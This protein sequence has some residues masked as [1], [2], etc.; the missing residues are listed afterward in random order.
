[1]ANFGDFPK[2]SLSSNAE[3]MSPSGE[4]EQ[5]YWRKRQPNPGQYRLSCAARVQGSLVIHVPEESQARKQIIRK[6]ANS[7]HV[8]I[9]PA[10]RQYFVK[11]KIVELG[12][13][14]GDWERLQAALPE[15]RI[16]YFALRELQSTLRQGHWEVTITVWN[17]AQIIRIQPG[18]KEGVYRMAIDI[19]STTVADHLVDLR[20]GQLLATEAAMNPQTAYGD[21]LMSRISYS[22]LNPDGL[23]KM[24]AAII[25]TLSRLI[26]RATQTAKLKAEDVTE[27]VLVG[28]TVMVELLLGIDPAPVGRT[29]FALATHDAIDVKARSLELTVGHR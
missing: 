26:K 29:P 7:R 20:T 28:N 6:S 22:M 27:L 9:D 17:G 11:V 12:D 23:A 25:E 18:Y 14:R 10:I 3:H 2:Y 4:A 21:D 24:H 8:E 1:M 13:N 5:A 16:D 15:L 19:G